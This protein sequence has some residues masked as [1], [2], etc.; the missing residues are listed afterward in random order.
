MQTTQSPL[1]T[2]PLS[3]STMEIADLVFLKVII[4]VVKFPFGDV[5]KN[6]AQH[7]HPRKK[8]ISE[9]KFID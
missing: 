7:A 5:L 4:A 3:S 6:T 9:T 2:I 8:V 1:L